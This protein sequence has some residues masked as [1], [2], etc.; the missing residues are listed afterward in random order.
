MVVANISYKTPAFPRSFAAKYTTL[1]SIK[2]G[3]TSIYFM[4]DSEI[5]IVVLLA[6]KCE[7]EKAIKL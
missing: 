6:D 1:F 7:K 3:L 4:A 2:Y 5:L